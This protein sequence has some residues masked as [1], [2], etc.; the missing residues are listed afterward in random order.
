MDQLAKIVL[1]FVTLISV[2]SISG[3]A[4]PLGNA[5]QPDDASSCQGKNMNNMK[6]MNNKWQKL[7]LLGKKYLISPILKKNKKW[8]DAKKKCEKKGGT[9]ATNLSP[10][11]FEE[12]SKLKDECFSRYNSYWVGAVGSEADNEW[13]W[14]SGERLPLGNPNWK[15]G[16]PLIRYVTDISEEEFNEGCVYIKFDYGS[17]L[18]LKNM[19]CTVKSAF[20]CELN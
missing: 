19:F 3:F 12:A 11:W 16:M 7:T 8:K 15:E 5:T 2:A 4:S 10:E 18:G 14:I 1:T 17:A 6:N 20:V 9:L 13:S